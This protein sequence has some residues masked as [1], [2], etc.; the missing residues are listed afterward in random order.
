MNIIKVIGERGVMP[1]CKNG[2]C[3]AVALVE[4][5]TVFVQGYMPNAAEANELSAPAGEG[6]VRMSLST[7]KRIAAQVLSDTSI[8]EASPKKAPLGDLPRPFPADQ[9]I[10]R[11]F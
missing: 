10:R 3:P 9:H 2:A 1:L 8:A 6:F 7:F 11:P 5:G 4:G